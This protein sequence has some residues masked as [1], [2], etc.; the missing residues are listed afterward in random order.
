MIN[1]KNDP[2]LA[3]YN[4][5]DVKEIKLENSLYSPPKDGQIYYLEIEQFS[6][7]RTKVAI[8]IKKIL[9]VDVGL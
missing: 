7:L 5:R 1:P 8:T 3:R 4:R 9:N 6:T 2:V